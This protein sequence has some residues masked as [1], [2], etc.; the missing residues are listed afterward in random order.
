METIGTIFSGALGPVLLCCIGGGVLFLIGMWGKRLKMY[1]RN[2][3][4]AEGRRKKEFGTQ[5]FIPRGKY[6]YVDGS[7]PD[8][9][10]VSRENDD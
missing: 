3:F 1:L 4:M 5:S 8:E 9:K 10:G 7:W 6:D 2:T